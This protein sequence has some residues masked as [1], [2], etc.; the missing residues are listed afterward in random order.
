VSRLP[1]ALR[2]AL[3]APL[4][5][6]TTQLTAW[7]DD[8][9][10]RLDEAVRDAYGLEPAAV[11]IALLERPGGRFLFPLIHRPPGGRAHA[12]QISLPGG[13]C[14]ARETLAACALR[15]AQE[16]IG[17]PTAAVE[18]LGELTPVPV[19]V[20]RYRIRPFV[21]WVGDPALAAREPEDWPIERAE[22]VSV[23]HAD[24]DL[25]ATAPPVRVLRRLHDG[26]VAAVPAFLVPGRLGVA[27]VWGAT[28]IILAEF[29]AVWRAVRARTD[30]SV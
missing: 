12:G 14:T 19:P 24:P 16:E 26:Q 7:P 27:E 18:I 2:A 22:V 21:G 8:L 6:Y 1:D 30:P 23:L 4:P 10:S 9:P 13:G 29:L 5:G 11:L 20:S 25:L 28:A 15:E 17:L 3:A